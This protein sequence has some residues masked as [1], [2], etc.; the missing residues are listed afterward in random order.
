MTTLTGF[1][2]TPANLLLTIKNFMT[3]TVGSLPA[4]EQ[5]SQLRYVAGDELVLQSSSVSIRAIVGMKIYQDS[6]TGIYSI[7]LNGFNAWNNSLP[8]YQQS[9]ALQQSQNLITLPLNSNSSNPNEIKY[10]IIANGRHLK[11]IARIGS[12]YHQAYGG[13][14]IPYGNPTEWPYPLCIGGS[15]LVNLSGVPERFS[16]TSNA[17]NAF[18]KPQNAFSVGSFNETSTLFLRDGGGNQLRLWN[19]VSNTITNPSAGTW[20][21]IEQLRETAGDFTKIR[22][23]T[24]NGYNLFPIMICNDNPANIYGEFDG[25]RFITGFN[26][27]TEDIVS[28]SGT[29]WLIMQNVYKTG[30]GE[31]CAYQ[32]N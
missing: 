26:N 31:F 10:W 21:Y 28:I 12:V 13:F 3:G 17:I 5:W 30:D 16:S 19:R 4:I 2:D 24:G 7:I 8:F 27:T 32:L 9:G 22:L 23:D 20:P 18:W 11:V 6:A 15:G 29:N 1:T 25:I 14:I